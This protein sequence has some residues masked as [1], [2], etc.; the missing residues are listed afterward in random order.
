MK[1]HKFYRDGFGASSLKVDLPNGIDYDTK[2]LYPNNKH[3][4]NNCLSSVKKNNDFK[5]VDGKR[6]HLEIEFS[7]QSPEF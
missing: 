6:T 5:P 4:A 2:F 3:A 7:K 1:D